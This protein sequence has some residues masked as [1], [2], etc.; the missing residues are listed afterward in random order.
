[1]FSAIHNLDLRLV[2][3]IEELWTEFYERGFVELDDLLM[4]QAWIKDLLAV[5]Y[6]FPE[7]TEKKTMAISSEWRKKTGGEL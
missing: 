4:A 6:V 3:R 1:M 7:L 2:E 5:G